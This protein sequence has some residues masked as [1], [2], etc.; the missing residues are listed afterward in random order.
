MRVGV[1]GLGVGTLAA[2]SRPGD[3]F[4]FYELDPDVARLSQGDAPV[5]SYV[6][7]AQGERRA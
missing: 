1:I 4:R 5:F 3:R 2:W 7:D 6:R